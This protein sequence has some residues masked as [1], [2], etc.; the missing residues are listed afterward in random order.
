MAEYRLHCF[1][2]S[3][4]A[5][6]AALM[7]ALAGCDWEPVWVDFFG[8]AT[9]TPDFRALNVMGEVPVLEH[10]GEVLSQSGAILDYLAAVTEQFDPGPENGREALRW[11]LFD[12]QK[13][14]G[15]LGPWRF[16][17]TVAAPEKRSAEVVAFLEGRARNALAAL[18]AHLAHRDW[19]AAD[20]M[21]IADIAAAGYVFYEDDYPIDWAAEYPGIDAWRGRIRGQDGWRHPYDLMPGRGR[22]RAASSE[23]TA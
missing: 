22:P 1:A 18:D 19:I 21:T 7:L 8:G 20:W 10:K 23:E 5:Y 6:K 9:R 15:Y 12:S 14:S 17:S 11:L 2:D 3:G 16:V 4:N 13:I